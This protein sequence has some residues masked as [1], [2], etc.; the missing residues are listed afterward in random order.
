MPSTTTINLTGNQDI[1]GLLGARKWAVQSLTYS[2]PTSSG[3]VTGYLA[4]EEP[5]NGFETLNA[6]QRA[7][8]KNIYSG[9]SAFTNLTFTE[10][11][12]G[13][14]DLRFA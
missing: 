6:T 9:L 4:G 13:V 1:D 14:G 3:E 5:S 12:G 8:V 2:F 11:S 10:V 7:V